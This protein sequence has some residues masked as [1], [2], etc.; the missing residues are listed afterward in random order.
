MTTPLHKAVIDAVAA[1]LGIPADV[2]GG[3]VVIAEWGD[4]AIAIDS[5]GGGPMVQELAR[6]VITN[7]SVNITQEW[8]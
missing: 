8:N 4:L 6:R 7:P 5:Y 1:A 3:F 2:L